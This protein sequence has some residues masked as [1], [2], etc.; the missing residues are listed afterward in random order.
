MLHYFALTQEDLDKQSDAPDLETEF[1]NWCGWHNDHGSLTGLVQALYMDEN[2]EIVENPDPG[3]GLYVKAR[4]GEII[5]AVIPSGHLIY[6]L[7]ES[8]QIHSGGLL[9]ATPH[10]VRG[11]K[12]TG[13]NRSTLAIFMEPDWDEPMQIPAGC[14]PNETGRTENLPIGVPSLHSRWNN[15]MDFFDFTKCTLA[16]YY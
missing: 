4:D 14:N 7:G 8:A 12:Q 3:A 1:S 9:Q 15:T 11:P 10:A 5:K 2:G 13:M 6:Q 16:A